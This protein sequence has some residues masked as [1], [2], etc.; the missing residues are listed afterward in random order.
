MTDA[1]KVGCRNPCAIVC[2]A[3]AQVFTVEHLDDL[4]RQDGLDLFGIRVLM[5]Q[6]TECV[7]TSP[8]D[9]RF[10]VLPNI[11]FTLF[12]RFLIRSMSRAGVLTPCVD[13]F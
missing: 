8:Y 11:S 9:C 2:V 4:G 1:R 13:F 12:K 10:C 3:Y 7:S 6:V 5:P